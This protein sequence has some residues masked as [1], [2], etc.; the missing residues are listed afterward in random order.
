[1]APDPKLDAAREKWLAVQAGEAGDLTPAEQARAYLEAMGIEPERLDVSAKVPDVLARSGGGGPAYPTGIPALDKLL[2]R[3]GE[4][5]RMGLG[6]GRIVVIN[7]QPYRGKSLLL[8]QLGLEMAKH[9]LR[10][11][12]LV[13]D[14]PQ[15]DAAQRIG[16][17]LGFAYKELNA[18]YPNVIS[19]LRQKM[20]EMGLDI[21]IVPDEEREEG[22]ISIEAAGK[23]LLAVDSPR[24]HVLGVDSLHT[25][26][27]EAEE[28]TDPPRVRIEKRMLALRKLRKQGVLILCTAE[29]SRA[30]YASKDP[31]ARVS[32]MAA[33]AEARAI[34]FGADL[35][36]FLTE[37]P[38]DSVNVQVPKNRIGKR[39]G[40]FFLI[41]EPGPARFRE[42]TEEELEAQAMAM[43]DERLLPLEDKILDLL[44]PGGEWMS[45]NELQEATNKK[46]SDVLR[47]VDLCIE[48]GKLH[49]RRRHGK[50]GGTE[51]GRPEVVP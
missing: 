1:M 47:A 12:L 25:C 11:V 19:E 42:E 15:E 16:Q 24:G 17:Q 31:S 46:R 37:G 2:L 5:Q 6:A 14:E 30:A 34:E 36:L 10:V 3:P 9:G 8:G 23:A 49:E 13:D 29:A 35:L 4:T 20:G 27:C 39:K 48:K 51:V 38:A 33:G 43:R 18:E 28:D 21:G 40:E 22:R 26:Y 50:G 45:R 32:P 44:P 41:L 7:G